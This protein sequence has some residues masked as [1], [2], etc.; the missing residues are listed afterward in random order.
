MVDTAF[1]C[2]VVDVKVLEVVVKIN[3]TRAK[4]A[5]Q[6]SCVRS[7]NSGDI[8]VTFPAERD[9]HAN[10]PFVK[11]GYHG[12]VELSSDVLHVVVNQYDDAKRWWILLTSPRNHATM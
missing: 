11:M 5:T 10:L 2:L 1:A 8:D 7:E 12:P 9:G 4:V 6:E 3:A